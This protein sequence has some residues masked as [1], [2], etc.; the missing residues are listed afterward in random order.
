MRFGPPIP[1]QSTLLLT[2]AGAAGAALSDDT[3]L[4]VFTINGVPVAD[5]G[6]VDYD[7]S[8]T[9]VEVHIRPTSDFVVS[10]TV[11][12]SGAFPGNNQWPTVGLD[13]VIFDFDG[14]A[15][16][17]NTLTVRVVAQDGVTT[18]DHVVTVR[19]LAVLDPYTSEVHGGWSLAR[20]LTTAYLGS[21]AFKGRNATTAAVAD[22]NT[23]TSGIDKV[24]MSALVGAGNEV[25]CSHLY[26][27]VGTWPNFT[28]ATAGT[29]PRLSSGTAFGDSISGRKALF[30]AKDA[31]R[32]LACTTQTA[33]NSW[34]AVIVSR[35]TGTAAE[36]A[37]MAGGSSYFLGFH[38][39]NGKMYLAAPAPLGATLL[40]YD[41]GSP[42][43]AWSKFANRP[44]VY[45]V[46]VKD[47]LQ[48]LYINGWKAG[49]T[50]AAGNFPLSMSHF[51]YC[52][53]SNLT[54]KGQQSEMVV[55]NSADAEG[56][57]PFMADAASY[58][59]AKPAV[60]LAGDSLTVG[61]GAT[62]SPLQSYGQQLLDTS[63]YIP[64]VV[65]TS[66]DRVDQVTTALNGA[67]NT[68]YSPRYTGDTVKNATVALCGIN[69]LA[70]G[71]SIAT[72]QTRL[73]ALWAQQRAA[74]FKVVA[75]TLT[76]CINTGSVVQ[77]DLIDINAW[78]RTQTASYD[79]LADLGASPFIGLG[80]QLNTTYFSV[81][82][83]HLNSTG[84]G[85][86]ASLDKAAL[87]TLYA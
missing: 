54:W 49:A 48:E 5:G 35:F 26:R 46:R 9:A 75:C 41:N 85:V 23:T 3:S 51:S 68:N 55:F 20:P 31:V 15:T 63:D 82:G 66:G 33:G 57:F 86:L 72:L 27:Q 14:M 11:L 47:G 74:G 44:M 69:D 22:I 8:V 40:S 79:A 21:P 62:G 56:F 7:I 38:N 58:Y 67:N 70:Q 18:Q 19:R 53:V 61:F 6:S 71:A 17:S 34:S 30:N 28:N 59:S 13:P 64:Y 10:M 16:G 78:I 36:Q 45:G 65:A 12:P 80:Q 77:Q 2:G 32:N 42:W 4:S 50:T 43:A 25:Y 73:S 1:L 83:V 84:Y 76:G 52:G 24:A 87:D 39:S 29:Q 81:D 60:V 37:T